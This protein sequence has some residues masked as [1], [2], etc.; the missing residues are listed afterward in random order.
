MQIERDDS[1]RF[2]ELGT[3]K[4][5]TRWMRGHDEGLAEW[6]KNVRRAYQPDRANVVEKHRVAVLLFKDADR[7]SP[8]RIGLLDVGGAS[9]EDVLAWSTWQDPSASSRG[10][11]VDEEETQGNGGKTYMYRLFTGSARILG[12]REGRLNCKGFDG[13]M[14]SLERG[15]PGFMPSTGA[16][17]QLPVVSWEVELQK[18][19]EPFDVT[20]QEL[21]QDMQAALRGRQAFTLVEGVSPVT[22][23]YKGKID[24]RDLIHKTLRHDQS[25]LAVQQVRIYAIHNG[26]PLNDN[27]PLELE[28]IEPHP[29]FEQPIVH[30]I[31]TELPDERGK[32]QST[33]LEGKRPKGRLILYTSRQDMHRAFKEL[34][35]RWKITY[36]TDY[37]MIGSKLVGELVAGTPGSYFVYGTVELSALEPDYVDHGR[38][39]PLDGPLVQAVDLFVAERI[40]ELAKRISERRKHELDQRALDEVQEEN[41]ILDRFKNRFLSASGLVGAGGLGEEG[42]GPK[43]VERRPRKPGEVAESIELSWPESTILRVGKS[44]GVRI[45]A[46]V[47]PRVLDASGR[48]VRD[49]EIEWSTADRHVLKC[50]EI[51]RLDAVD[52][53][54]TEIWARVKG[55]AIESVRIRAEV[56]VIDHVLLTPRKLQILSGKREQI[57]AEVTNDEG[58]RATDV[59]LTWKHS[60]DDPLIVRIG[61]RGLVTGNRLGQTTIT[62]GAG[63]PDKGGVWARIGVEVAVVPNPEEP[64]RG[65]GFPELRLTGRDIDPD[66]GEIREGDPDQ[67]ALWQEVSDYRNN[68]WWLNLESPEAAFLFKQRSENMSLWR[69]FHAQKLTDMVIQIYMKDEF[70]AKGEDE[71]PDLWSR[72]KAVLETYQILVTQEMWEKLQDYVVTGREP[73]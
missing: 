25:T 40:R 51:D 8:A 22:E 66:T 56:W 73:D 9:L 72:H 16:G 63:D 13:P 35:P 5:V 60:A 20:I 4:A 71:R 12:V 1:I 10:A 26:R 17:R 18:A 19:L 67:P 38:R 34:K 24:A 41:R 33:T 39:R 50:G 2:H 49:A 11:R 54:E 27:K 3:L 43:L 55:T 69:S 32:K 29:G 14:G 21:P 23:F 15:T 28:P 59:L 70:D 36:R 48:V 37:Q 53:G 52:K 45:N 6:L 44:V 61:P 31:P 62:A 42:Q 46:I 47:H 7:H 58:L 57:V 65:G 30:E 68:I 64:E